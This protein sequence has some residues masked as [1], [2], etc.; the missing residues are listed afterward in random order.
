MLLPSTGAEVRF[1]SSARGFIVTFERSVARLISARDPAFAPL[2]REPRVTSLEASGEDLHALE[3][4]VSALIRE[5]G[6]AA[7]AR[8]T[9]IEAHLQLLM[10]GVLRALEHAGPCKAQAEECPAGRPA[11][12]V[13]E[14]LKLAIAHSRHHWYLSDYARALHVSAGY[15]RAVCVRVTGTS[16]IQLIHECLIREAKQQLITTAQSISAIASELGFEDAA[17]FCRLF[18]AKS[19]TSPTQYRLSFRNA[20]PST[21]P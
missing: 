10:T 13:D 2:F 4:T 18:H 11:R 17:Y 12:I 9:A 21:S 3:M 19:G 1:G 5:L 14:F 6:L 16:P 8:M 20:T 7:A 15:L